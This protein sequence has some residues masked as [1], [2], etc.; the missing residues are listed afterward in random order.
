[1]PTPRTRTSPAVGSMS[2][3]IIFR[4]VVLPDP[5]VPRIASTSPGSTS[6]L[7]PRSA[8]WPSGYDLR[9]SRQ[10]TAGWSDFTMP[11]QDVY[12]AAPG[13]GT[14]ATAL[15]VLSSTVTALSRNSGGDNRTTAIS[16]CFGKRDFADHD[17][18]RNLRLNCQA[19]TNL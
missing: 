7:T 16:L 9:T 8:S 4:S 3:L 18:A 14:H 2:R 15:T 1:M 5:L 6:R 11:P 13:I 12:G 10:A 17:R 19:T